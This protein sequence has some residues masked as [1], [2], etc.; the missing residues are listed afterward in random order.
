MEQKSL[1]EKDVTGTVD[2]ADCTLCGCRSA[3]SAV[4]HVIRTLETRLKVQELQL[5]RLASCLNVHRI[6][7]LERATA[8]SFS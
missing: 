4:H 5:M 3:R 6:H 7:F 8:L 2:G 1:L